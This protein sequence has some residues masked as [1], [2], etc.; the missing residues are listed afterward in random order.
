M[1][2]LFIAATEWQPNRFALQAAPIL[3][4]IASIKQKD[5]ISGASSSSTVDL[6]SAAEWMHIRRFWNG[7]NWLSKAC[8]VQ[9]QEQRDAIGQ[10]SK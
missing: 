8:E 9:I 10:Y 6:S 7:V 3:I 5:I 1:S 2:Q 4:L